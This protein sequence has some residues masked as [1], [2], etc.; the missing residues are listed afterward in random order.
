MKFTVIGCVD[1]LSKWLGVELN[2][3]NI[4]KFIENTKN[5]GLDPLGERGE[6]HTIVVKPLDD[7]PLYRKP[8]G[9]G[10]VNRHVFDNYHILRLILWIHYG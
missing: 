1:G 5:L 7:G 2:G 3:E 4:D 10:A 6:Y 9:Y 8:L